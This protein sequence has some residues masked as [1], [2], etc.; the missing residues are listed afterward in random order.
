VSLECRPALDLV[1]SYGRHP[2]VLLYCDPPYLAATRTGR[3]RGTP[4]YR[5]DMPSEDEHR[6]LADA[7]HRCQAA[8]AVSGYPHPLYDDELYPPARWHR[9]DLPAH[10]GNATGDRRRVEALW[11]N[12]PLRHD[13]F[14]DHALGG[15]A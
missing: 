5:H 7:L 15:P 1:T 9:V 4:A 2:G 8:V 13:L 11:S 14:T 3:D 10:T 6:T 12:W